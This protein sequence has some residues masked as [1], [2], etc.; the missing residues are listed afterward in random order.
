MVKATIEIDGRQVP[1]KASAMIPRIYRIQFHRDIFADLRKLMGE[2]QD[3]DGDASTMDIG[4]L[5]IFENIAYMM[6]KYA[7]PEGVP[8]TVEEWL[9]GFNTFSIYR[10]FPQIL[11]LWG[12]NME[13]EAEQK[14]SLARLTA[15]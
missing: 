6:A 12:L 2:I 7:D 9:D 10:I 13:T 15:R 3:S 8:D 11:D 14:K 1:F 4:S 5:L